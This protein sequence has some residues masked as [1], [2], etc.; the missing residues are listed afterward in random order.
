MRNIQLLDAGEDVIIL[1]DGNMSA[2]D[3]IDELCFKGGE[4]L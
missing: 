4:L 1:V 2:S 3:D